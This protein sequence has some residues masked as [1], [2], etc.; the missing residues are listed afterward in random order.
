[1][2]LQVPLE[3]Y[4]Y[5]EA[6][7]GPGALLVSMAPEEI[8]RRTRRALQGLPEATG[9]MTRMGSRFTEDGPRM[10]AL[11][12]VAR[13]QGLFFVDSQ[14]TPRSVGY[15]LA[16][17]VGLRA[18]R[19]QL[20]LDPDDREA[21]VRARLAEVPRWVERRGTVIAV[22][23]GRLLTVRL[24]QEAIPQWEARG[25]RLVPVSDLLDAPAPPP[26]R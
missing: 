15:D 19:R 4:R 7:P 25:L 13:T 23:H 16:R 26:S 17:Q 3:P 14:T 22:G 5:P 18:A 9:V 2:L 1:M 24:L 20:F 6:D 11:L 10:G 8:A 12:E 21:T